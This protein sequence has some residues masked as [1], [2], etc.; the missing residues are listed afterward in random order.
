[1][2]PTAPPTLLALTP[3][4]LR[5]GPAG[6]AAR[7]GLV[8]RVRA[9]GSAGLGGVLLR[10]VELRTEIIKRL[11]GCFRDYRDPELIEHTVEELVRQRILGL[12]LGYEDLSDHDTLRD[13]ALLATAVGK[14]EEV[15]EGTNGEDAPD[16][17]ATEPAE[18]RRR[19]G[20]PLSAAEV[21]EYCGGPC[22]QA[23][24]EDDDT[25]DAANVVERWAFRLTAPP[26]APGAG[27]TSA[28]NAAM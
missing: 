25:V 18:K 22:S 19:V 3:G 27:P 16:Q 26:T 10:E 13:D 21:F 6:A 23:I 8:E 15:G 14:V 5:P 17:A 2:S 1:M 11:A 24:G 12:C 4:E 7:Q 9:L 28:M 20:S